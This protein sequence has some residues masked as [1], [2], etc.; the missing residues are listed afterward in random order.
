M[1]VAAHAVENVLY[2]FPLAF[3]KHL[4][5]SESAGSCFQGLEGLLT[6]LQLCVCQR[7]ATPPG[8]PALAGLRAS[9]RSGSSSGRGSLG[10]NTQFP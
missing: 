4:H 1:H 2:S 9:E 6:A 3:I 10:Q 7:E 5:V 8:G